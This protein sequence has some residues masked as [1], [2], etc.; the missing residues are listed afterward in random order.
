MGTQ[1][2]G[3]WLD[4]LV[5]GSGPFGP[6]A[7]R[8]YMSRPFV[9]QSFPH[10]SPA[11]LLKCHVAPRFWC[12]MSSGSK[13]KEPKWACLIEAKASHW[14]RMWAEVSSSAP[15]FLQSGLSL[16]PIKWRCLHRILCPVRSP[17]TTLD[18][19]LLRDKNL[20]LVS[21]LGPEINS[22]AC[23]WEGPRCCHRLQC[24]FTSQRPILLL[25]S[26][27]E[28]PRADSR[29]TYPLAEPL[30]TSLPAVSL[31]LTPACPGTQ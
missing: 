5:V 28:T 20:A 15:H 26:C 13:K 31:P 8:P 25:R 3:T 30:L 21:W 16:S 22:W 9:P 2:P 6:D 10:G 19:F 18:C 17:V 11:A 7:N 24:W 29:P 14:Q 12:F 23:R 4:R 27:F 1:I